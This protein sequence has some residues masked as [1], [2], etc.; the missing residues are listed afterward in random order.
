M[1]RLLADENVKK[2]LVRGLLRRNTALDIVTVQDVGLRGASDD[3][4]LEW[5]AREGRV[6]V[7]HDIN[8]MPEVAYRRAE[9]GHP[10]P[11]VFAIVWSAP[12]G[13]TIEDLLLLVEASLPGEWEG[14]VVYLPL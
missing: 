8:T 1:L 11:G 3:A 5:A 6:V 13:R 14:R 7:T 2:Q 9:M 10:M 12:L 4:I